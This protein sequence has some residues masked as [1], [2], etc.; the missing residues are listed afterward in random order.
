MPVLFGRLAPLDKERCLYWAAMEYWEFGDALLLSMG[1]DP[2]GN[3]GILLDKETAFKVHQDY[4]KRK[5]LFSRAS[6]VDKIDSLYIPWDDPKGLKRVYLPVSFSNWAVKRLPSF[7]QALFDS[8]M[9]HIEVPQANVTSDQSSA[10]GQKSAEPTP[11]VCDKKTKKTPNLIDTAEASKE[12]LDRRWGPHREMLKRIE[13]YVD[14]EAIKLE[15]TC[16]PTH[17][18]NIVM[19]LEGSDGNMLID[20]TELSEASALNYIKVLYGKHNLTRSQK[21]RTPKNTCPVHCDKK[22][23][24]H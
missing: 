1:F 13:K 12:M 17:T 19:N 11:K 9:Q 14:I 8:V 6:D 20:T 3:D 10:G 2:H 18:C 7:P 22:R 24:K 21:G 16:L 5:I 23:A 4:S 15:C